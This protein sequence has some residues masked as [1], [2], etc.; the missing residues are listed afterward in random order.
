MQLETHYNK[1]Y[2]EAI[3][4]IST[5]NY[6]ID[7]LI[8][9]DADKRTGI[10]LIIR[11]SIEV[12]QEIQKFLNQLKKIEPNQ[13]YYPSTDVHITVMSIISCYEDFDLNKIELSEYIALIQE[14]IIKNTALKIQ[15]KGLTAS[16]S[17]FMIQGFMNNNSLNAIRD[18]L[19][20]AFKSSALEQSIDKRYAIQ[21]AHST[22]VRFSEKLQHKTE[23]L[24]LIKQFRNTDFGTF[25][26]DSY[27]L[28]YNDWYHRKK[29]VKILHRFNT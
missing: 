20:S 16:H 5:D 11:P 6:E 3:Q 14:C 9:S 7:T 15:F 26:I 1:L 4:E 13:Y 27:E 10:T 12:K 2:K 29:R 19:R 25:D 28:V 8:N 21:T 22:V 24:N 23:F 18:R 17:C